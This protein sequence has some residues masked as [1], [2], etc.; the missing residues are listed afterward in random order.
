M[1]TDEPQTIR[2]KVKGIKEVTASDI[3]AG[4]QIEILNP[5]LVIAHITD[6]GTELDIEM[7]V[8]KG[9]GY[10]SKEVLQKN[11]VDIGTITLDASFTPIRRVHYEVENMRVGDRTDF[12]RLKAFY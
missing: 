6:K 11:K 1:T 12:N 7:T 2:L 4:G 9:L 3:E 10:V 8:E 5:D